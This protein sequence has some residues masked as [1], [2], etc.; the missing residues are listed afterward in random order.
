MQIAVLGAGAMGSWFGGLLAM[1]SVV[2]SNKTVTGDKAAEKK[3]SEKTAPENKV[4]LITTNQA[5]RDAIT[6][7]GLSIKSP[8]QQHTIAVQ[9]V[10][11][12]AMATH[13]DSSIDLIL[14]LTK[15]FQTK[16]ALSGIANVIDDNTHALSLQ[17]GLGNATAMSSLLPL[18]RIWVGVSMMPVEKT[19]PGMVTSK[20]QGSSYFGNAANENNQP[21]AKRILDT[22][23]QAN[24]ELHHDV[25]IHSRIWEKVAFNSGMNALCALSHGRPG[26]IGESAGAKLLAQRTANEVV[27]VARSQQV[28][29]DLDKVYGMI[30]QSCTKHSNH[31]PSMLQDLLSKRQTEVDALNGAVVQIGKANGIP[32]PINDTL[33]TLVRLAE[34]SHQRYD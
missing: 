34:M 22:F 4:W 29:L 19:A 1:P 6:Q 17:N 28:E 24:I 9:A 10:S 11:P 14:V 26:T 23:T 8:E 12:I 7:N 2:T 21:M 27:L 33:A 32:T 25:N 3:A 15:A 31:I 16:D 30:E 18:N 5:H 13:N 20:G